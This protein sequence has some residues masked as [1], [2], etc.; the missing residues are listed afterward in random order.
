MKRS[1][2]ALGVTYRMRA[3]VCRALLQQP[4]RYFADGCFMPP[5]AYCRRRGLIFAILHQLMKAA[6]FLDS[7]CQ[8]YSRLLLFSFA[9]AYATADG[10]RGVEFLRCAAK[11]DG[12][13]D[14]K[15][16]HYRPERIMAGT[17]SARGPMNHRGGRR[18]DFRRN[19]AL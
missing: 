6:I 8:Q 1:P 18:S 4:I 7:R 3:S 15:R 9:A 12:H 19:N 16:G 5:H 13:A 17:F 14:Y 10:E 11:L 2:L